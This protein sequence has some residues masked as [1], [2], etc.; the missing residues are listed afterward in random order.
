MGRHDGGDKA[1]DESFW[2]ELTNEGVEEEMDLFCVVKDDED[3]D[4][5]AQQLG[6]LDS[7]ST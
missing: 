6:F 1:L 5:L 7:T 3:M 2:K 4:M